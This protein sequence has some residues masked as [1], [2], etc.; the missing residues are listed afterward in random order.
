MRIKW[1]RRGTE[2]DET[3]VAQRARTTLLI[4]RAEETFAKSEQTTTTFKSTLNEL[5]EE[6]RRQRKQC[7]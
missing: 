2:T 3:D 6:L 5:A 4:D 1:F 7:P